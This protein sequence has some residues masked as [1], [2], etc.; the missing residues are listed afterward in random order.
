MPYYEYLCSS[1]EGSFDKFV[2]FKD[3]EKMEYIKCELCP[4]EGKTAKRVF[5][6]E[7]VNMNTIG[8]F[9][10]S[11]HQAVRERATDHFFKHEKEDWEHKSGMKYTKSKEQKLKEI[12]QKHPLK[13]GG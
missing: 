1:C 9:S 5:R 10:K 4:S 13:N 3:F 6:P 2:E 12:N 8:V 7:S 11:E